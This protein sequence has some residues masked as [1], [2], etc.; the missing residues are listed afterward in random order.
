[1]GQRRQEIKIE[2]QI[3]K[4]PVYDQLNYKFYRKLWVLGNKMQRWAGKHMVR[5]IL[6]FE[7][8]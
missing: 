2:N 1:M 3:Y 6:D 7:G 8:R 4:S 5:I